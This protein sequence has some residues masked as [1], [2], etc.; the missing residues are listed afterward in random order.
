MYICVCICIYMC[1]YIPTYIY[2]YAYANTDTHFMR[3]TYVLEGTNKSIFIVCR[4]SSLNLTQKLNFKL[5]KQ[6][7]RCDSESMSPI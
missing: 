7:K 2:V 1:I 3:H 5:G 6:M 4:A